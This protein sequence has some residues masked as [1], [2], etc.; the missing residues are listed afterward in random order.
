MGNSRLH[1]DIPVDERSLADITATD[2][3]PFQQ[4]SPVLA[5]IMPAHVIY[6][7][8]DAVPAGF[9]KVWLQDILRKELNYSGV[10]FSDDYPWPVP[11]L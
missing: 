11:M 1:V 6:P 9:S 4:L 3:I 5:G 8:V 10:L 7:E 2:L